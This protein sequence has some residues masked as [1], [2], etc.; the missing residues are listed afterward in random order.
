LRAAQRRLTEL[1][2]VQRVARVVTSALR[3]E[4]IC[5]AVVQ[6]L[7]EAFGYP[8]VSIYLR[9]GDELH[10]QA[11]IGYHATMDVIRLDQGVSGRVVRSGQPAFVY[12][13]AEDPEFIAVEPEIC[14]G[15]IVPLRF[16]DGPALGT[17][18]VEST[19]DPLLTDDDLSLLSLLADQISVAV[20][21][22]RL[23]ARAEE[24]VHR[25]RSLVQAA[26][27]VIF[28]VD[29]ELCVTEFN[30]EAERIFGVARDTVIGRSYVEWFIAEHEHETIRSISHRALAGE[31]L[32]PFE[33]P[34]DCADGVERSF[35]WT[36]ARRLDATGEPAELFVVGQDITEQR[37][38]ERAR[39]DLERKMLEAQRLE[40]LG[41]LASGIA[42][43]FNNLL[44]A[45]LGNASLLLLDLPPATEVY[46]SARQIELVAQRAADLV[47]QIMAYAG[48]GRFVL[49]RLSLSELV[50]EMLVLLRASI[51]KG[52]LLVPQLAAD[53]P[54]VEIDAAQIRQVV[55][56]LVVNA[57][58]A[59]D[60]RGGPITIITDLIEL[61]AQQAAA[62]S[63]TP[64]LAPGPYVSLSVEDGGA[65]IDE[66]T[67]TRIFDPFFTTKFTGRGL[68]LAAVLGIVR[69]HKGGLVAQSRLGQGSRF[70]VLLPPAHPSA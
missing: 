70:T 64:G 52:V 46:H 26:G 31:Q 8:L 27:S 18:S 47:G 25:F 5:A 39:H 20:V 57:S 58:E 45:I 62:A 66:A 2:T 17:I 69:A 34:V 50:G 24:S 43:D 67:L 54:P 19:G 32:R 14:Q 6:Q 68:G 3:L 37:E 36:V 40:S 7:H 21:N 9:E 38:A 12:N 48:R 10:L 65:G 28:C 4:Q 15:I 56:N 63:L 30:R 16:S 23:F 44:T 53:L 51:S 61:D 35:V 11:S 22:A 59:L 60:E 49:Q 41:V 13:A 33:W 1:A 29:A 42:H 55:M